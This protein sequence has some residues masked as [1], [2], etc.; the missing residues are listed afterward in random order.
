MKYNILV[1][2][3][4]YGIYFLNNLFKHNPKLGYELLTNDPNITCLYF[5]RGLI[6]IKYEIQSSS[7]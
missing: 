7:Y 1:K 3:K 5:V 2:T 4:F 6:Y